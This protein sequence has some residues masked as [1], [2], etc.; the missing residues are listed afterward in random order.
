VTTNK[1]NFTRWG[2]LSVAGILVILVVAGAL[3]AQV[4][5][6]RDGQRGGQ[7]DG[8]FGMHQGMRGGGPG[9][10]MGPQAMIGAQFLMQDPEIMEI[11]GQIKVIEGINRL[12]L[13]RDQVSELR[14]LA[15]EAQDITES[16]LGG[17]RADVKNALED[18]LDNVLD[19]G[20]FEQGLM[21]EIMEQH[22]EGQ[23]P[24]VIR[25]ELEGVLNRA[26]ELLTDAQRE[27]IMNEAAGQG[28]G[29]RGD[30]FQGRGGD[31]MSGQ[32]GQNFNDDQ[33]GRMQEQFGDR[34]GQFREGAVRMKMMMVLLSP[35]AVD[36][37]DLW[38][39]ESRAGF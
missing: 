6:R 21:R 29:M 14:G 8:G 25:E 1:R 26:V 20:E 16:H 28:R 22:R 10:G 34:M 27:Q 9:G 2:L 30:G 37:M 31:G 4:G 38:L 13:D 17:V 15:I 19:G 23:D 35:A 12:D 36:G 39:D 5:T 33:R 24:G 3:F 7:R 32:R 18:Q 11:M